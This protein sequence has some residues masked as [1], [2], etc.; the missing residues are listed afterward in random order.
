MRSSSPTPTTNLSAAT[1]AAAM[2]PPRRAR[3]LG[4]ARSAAGATAATG[5]FLAMALAFAPPARADDAAVHY[6]TGLM[7]KHEGRT[8][9]AIAE[10]EKALSLRP[11]Y[12]AAT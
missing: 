3:A 2:A 11:D 4:W 10:V 12:A 1:A 6:N 5:A 7:L 9:E 8:A